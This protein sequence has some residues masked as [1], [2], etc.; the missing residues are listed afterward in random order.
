M[1]N[2]RDIKVRKRTAGSYELRYTYNG[3]QKSIYGQSI[4][5]CRAKYSEILQQLKKTKTRK[6]ML[7]STWYVKYVELYKQNVIKPGTL[8]NMNGNFQKHIL[9]YIGNKTLKQIKCEDIQLIVNNMVNFPRQQT[10]VFDQLNACLNQAIKCGYIDNN[11]CVATCIKKHKGNKGKSLTNEQLKILIEYLQSH[12]PP[13][14]NLIY[15]YLSTGMRRNELLNVRYED[16]DLEKCEIYVRGTKTTNSVRTIQVPL[17][18]LNLFPKKPIPFIDW[19]YN[20]VDREFKKICDKLH[21]K[22]IVIH[23]L[24]HTYAT[25]CV[26]AGVPPATLQKWMGHS[27]ISITLDVYTH[28]SDE[29]KRQSV[30]SLNYGFIP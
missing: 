6:S 8:K 18:V 11:P 21:F 26:E 9:P 29:F 14:T 23:S 4:A 15:L 12:N 19:T 20:K 1:K 17:K 16:L 7:F 10:I 25:R 3:K 28:I 24:R 5:V 22:G 2:V 27:S 13:I 30:S